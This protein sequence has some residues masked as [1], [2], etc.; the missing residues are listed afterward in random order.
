MHLVEEQVFITTITTTSPTSWPSW[1]GS[2]F[3][4]LLMERL[5]VDYGK[6]SK[7]GFSI[8]PAPQVSMND[9]YWVTMMS[10][11]RRWADKMNPSKIYPAPQVIIFGRWWCHWQESLTLREMIRWI[12]QNFPG[13][14]SNR[15]ALQCCAIHSHNPWTLRLCLPRWQPSE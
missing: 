9:Y 5:S 11:A 6:K 10:V 1:P 8:Y 3:A 15:G 14:H 13:L 4:S 2:G 12:P 7:L